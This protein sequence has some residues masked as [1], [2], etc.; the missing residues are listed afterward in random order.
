MEKLI[1]DCHAHYYDESFDLD[2]DEV[3]SSLP[4]EGVC[5][6]INSGSDILTSK[7]C[8]EIS[9]KYPYCLSTVG[10]HPES[11]DNF[12]Y[13]FIGELENLLSCGGVIGI[14]EIGLDYY[15][16]S[17]NCNLQKEI[18]INQVELSKKYSLPIVVH[19]RQAHNDTLEII[20]SYRPKGVI[21]C[22]SGDLEMA[23][24]LID[25]GMFI[26][27]GG[28]IT[29][30]NAGDLVNTV[31]NIP[32]ECILLET[33][34]PYLSPVPYRGKRCKSLY[35]K[36]VADK[37]ADIKNVSTQEVLEVT[38]KNSL[39]LFNLEDNL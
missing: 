4:N 22:F 18:F 10:V 24:K 36:Y 9:K 12:D 21:H 16:S 20:K 26:G 3:L 19:D 13:D 31:E 2:R 29:F 35:I 1:F 28:I 39:R 38:R 17:E 33:D 8:I 25:L 37:I 34:A 7:E 14:G 5:A 23:K 30:K 27:I 32:L 11:A 6:V 15:Y